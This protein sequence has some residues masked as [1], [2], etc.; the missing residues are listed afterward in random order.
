MIVFTKRIFSF[1]RSCGRPQI[2]VSL[3]EVEYFRGL[4]FTWTKIAEMIGIS[5]S[6]LYRFLE[7]EGISSTR[8]YSEISSSDLDRA[9][10]AIKQEHPNDG[11][12]MITGHLHSIGIVVPRSKLR[13][14][15][16]RIDPFSTA[17]RRS[18][19]IRRRIYHVEGPNSLWH[20]DGHHKLIKWRF[21]VHGGIDGF[22][23]TIV[24][25]HCSTNNRSSTVLSAFTNAVSKYG[26]PNQV[27]S[28]RGGENVRVWQYMFE[29]C[30]SQ[31]AVLVGSSTHN[32]RIERLWR[33]V[34]RCVGVLFA[35]LFRE[36]ENDGILSSLDEL[37]LFC[38]HT[39]FLPRI[40]K[41]LDSFVQSW[42]N[43]PVS[44]EH[45][46]T[47]NQ[48]FVEGAIRQNMTPSIPVLAG[49]TTPVI[50]ASITA[51]RVPRS[52]FDPCDSLTSELEQHDLL[53][54]VDDFGYSLY[55]YIRHLCIR[56][57]R[58]CNECSV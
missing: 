6:T 44:T 2:Q 33:D 4:G 48:L 30:N 55:R 21:V 57:L 31:S 54:V 25:L 5:R 56:H 32:E 10:A 17:V 8:K 40:N 50:P 20:I 28:D 7:R 35:D 42:N 43:H 1:L 12:R 53:C 23:R 26:I 58:S 3:D 38:L 46:R 13:A 34:Y 16:H 36:M 52:A 51:V 15:I 14:S 41:A 47:P 45:N 24:Y 39:T 27:R 18:I 19:T 29:Q 49:S 22:S 37:D 9:V 11:E